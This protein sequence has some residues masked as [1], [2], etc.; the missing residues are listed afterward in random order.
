MWTGNPQHAAANYG[1]K[2]MT[3]MGFEHPNLRL[4]QHALPPSH[5]VLYIIRKDRSWYA[6]R[7]QDYDNPT[8]MLAVERLRLVLLHC[9]ISPQASV[10]NLRLPSS[11]LPASS[12]Y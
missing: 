6:D 11:P 8:L 7:A 12:H 2:I 10:H 3:A 5:P 1:N 4:L 9:E